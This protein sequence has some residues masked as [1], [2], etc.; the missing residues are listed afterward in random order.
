[1]GKGGVDGYQICL[2]DGT[3]P[4][5]SSP[6]AAELL[7]MAPE[8]RWREF[9]KRKLNYATKHPAAGT[10][11]Y[12][13]REWE[14]GRNEMAAIYSAMLGV[15]N[16]VMAAAAEALGLVE[17]AKQETPTSSAPDLSAFGF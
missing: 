7:S 4:T 8:A 6:F 15:A 14:A 17:P 16:P 10:D 5:L 1:M 12:K 13:I 11:S 2:P 3:A 9:A